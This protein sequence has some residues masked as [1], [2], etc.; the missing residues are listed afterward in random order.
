MIRDRRRIA[1]SGTGEFP[2]MI[3][4]S[5]NNAEIEVIE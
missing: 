1:G 2:V 5:T 3:L 4:F